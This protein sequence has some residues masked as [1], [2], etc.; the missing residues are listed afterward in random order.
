MADQQKDRAQTGHGHGH[1][2]A[3]TR[4]HGEANGL[5]AMP[6]RMPVRRLWVLLAVLV[7]LITGS[8][9]LL[10]ELFKVVGDRRVTELNLGVA[11]AELQQLRE[12]DRAALGGYEQIDAAAG[13]YRIPVDRAMERLLADPKLI[14]PLA[15]PPKEPAP[16]AET[17]PAGAPGAAAPGGAAP[18]VVPGG[19]APAGMAPGAPQPGEARGQQQAPGAAAPEGEQP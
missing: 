3:H 7:V 18:G 8:A 5:A 9:I 13:R 10:T 15:E 14:R 11:G 16:G 4:E 12:R 2:P 19:A 1:G 17:A 6:D